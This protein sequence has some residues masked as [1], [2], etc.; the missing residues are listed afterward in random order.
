MCETISDS[1]SLCVT[2]DFAPWTRDDT[3]NYCLILIHILGASYN[4]SKTAHKN[5]S[6]K[7]RTCFSDLPTDKQYIIVNVAVVENNQ[8]LH[9]TN[10]SINF[11]SS[12]NS[13]KPLCI[14]VYC[15]SY[16]AL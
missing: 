6:G 7:G 9:S 5:S 13:S 4:S 14:H 16:R 15:V 11:T 3:N 2:C 10:V 12:D 1:Q 8:T